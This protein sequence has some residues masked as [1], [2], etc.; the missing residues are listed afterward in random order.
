M[1]VIFKAINNKAYPYTVN[2]ED[3]ISS[4]LDKLY[5]DANINKET[6]SFRII[7]QGKILKPDQLFSEFSKFTPV[8]PKDK[9]KEKLMFVFMATKN[10]P[11]GT[12]QP[13]VQT[14]IQ[15][16]PVIPPTLPSTL[17]TPPTPSTNAG[18]V[19]SLLTNT[20]DG[21]EEAMEEMD[22]SDKLR[23]ALVGMMVFIRS[24]PQMMELFNNNFESFAQ[25][26]MSPQFKPMFDSMLN[27][28]SA[29]DEQL[30]NLT[31][32]VLSH[33]HG[34]SDSSPQTQTVSLTQEDINNIATLEA[35]GFHK[36]ECV[37]AYVLANKNLDMAASM[38]MDM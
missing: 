4:V 36:Q 1:N 5:V 23:A 21:Y 17:P 6:N 37:Q 30:D 3:P 15:S 12:V 10:K 29:G 14:Q 34:H 20:D 8:N 31:D 19:Q 26:I 33:G 16:V 2:P 35:L 22:E 28:T 7:F 13:N 38:L 25:I 18:F 27:D 32:S 11:A 9:E 24:Q